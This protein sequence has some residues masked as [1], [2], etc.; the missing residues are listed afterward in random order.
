MIEPGAFLQALKEVDDGAEPEDVYR[1][2]MAGLE[3]MDW[4][5]DLPEDV[6]TEGCKVKFYNIGYCPG[7]I[8]VRSLGGAE[9]MVMTCDCDCHG[10]DDD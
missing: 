6:H 9:R 4:V 8:C 3:D 2:Y 10:S 1:N 7:V 5:H